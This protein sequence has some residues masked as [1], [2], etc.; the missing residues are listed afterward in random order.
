MT[1]IQQQ[2]TPQAFWEEYYGRSGRVWSGRPNPL[3]V[4]EAA[5][6]PAGSALDL[7]CGEGADAVW[8]AAEG[9]NV[10]AVDVSPTALE[11][12]AEHAV[13]AGCEDR[14]EWRRHD[15]STSFPAGTYD[16]VSLQFLHSPVELPVER[17]LRS[18]AAAVA[19]GG[20]LLF[21]GHGEFPGRRHAHED[22]RYPTPEELMEAMGL[23][24]PDWRV[25]VRESPRR[26][27]TGPEGQ[28]GI[29]TDHVLRVRRLR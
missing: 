8:L 14:I 5:D 18:A 2:P 7:G 28:V 12:A 15:L 6:L 26:E 24:S 20:V 16:L 10:T 23:P 21:V 11:R 9:W 4:R 25:E 13:A 27:E 1:D 19:P 22:V 17:I 3:L 29:R